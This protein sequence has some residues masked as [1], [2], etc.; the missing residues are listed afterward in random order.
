[1][2]MMMTIIRKTKQDSCYTIA[3]RLITCGAICLE[4]SVDS[5]HLPHAK[6]DRGM[7][8]YDD[9]DDNGA[10]H[11]DRFFSP[12]IQNRIM[13]YCVFFQEFSKVCHLSLAR[14]RLLLV[15]QQITSQ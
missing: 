7:L 2:T 10:D 1:M 5:F 9:D 12:L 11:D 14:T 4:A 13:K 8:Y 15:V 3:N 6:S